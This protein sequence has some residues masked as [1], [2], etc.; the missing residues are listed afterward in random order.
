MMGQQQAAK[1]ISAEDTL[2]RVN[3]VRYVF[4]AALMTVPILGMLIGAFLAIRTV[5]IIFA[6]SGQ[7]AKDLVLAVGTV[8]VGLCR[9]VRGRLGARVRAH[10][11]GPDRGLL[12]EFLDPARRRFRTAR[13][14]LHCAGYVGQRLK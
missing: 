11:V 6:R 5:A 1:T 2:N 8:A 9:H 7:L 12:A 10:S 14:Y 13:T 4:L 3:T